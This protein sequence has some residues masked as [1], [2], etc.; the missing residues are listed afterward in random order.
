MLINGKKVS[1]LSLGTASYGGGVSEADAFRLMDIYRECGGN[2]FDTA[3]VYGESESVI[4]RYLKS[5][6][7]RDNILISTKGAHYDVV[8]KEKR[9]SREAI[10]RDVEVS[11]KNLGID[12]AD[13]YWLHRDD[14]D[15]PVSEIM[16]ILADL[17]KEGRILS[18]GVS[19][20]SHERIL[21]AN[22]YAS[23][24]GMPQIISSQI[25][26]SAAVTV[27]ERDPTIL[28][29]DGKSRV[30]Y[31][32]ENM[33][34]FAYTSQARGLFTKLER[35]GVEGISEGLKREFLC[36]ETLR[37]FDVLY[38]IACELSRPIGQV[39][40]AAILCDSELEIIPIIGGKSQE[41]IKDSFRA[42]DIKLSNEQID[43]IFGK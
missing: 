32:R 26:H 41:Q 24:N 15:V 20:W 29:L 4:G 40:L 17:V 28:S 37:R 38:E 34:I 9:V 6:G 12:Y 10:C 16:G 23:A 31:K 39:A 36:E 35:L 2:I 27:F 3:R 13:I 30:Y 8:T 5:R 14:E 7:C 42:L 1:A 25:K 22:E 33:P 18:V 11:F 43:K 19:N 21:A